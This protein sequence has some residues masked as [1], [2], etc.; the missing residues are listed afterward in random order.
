MS[1]YD[2]VDLSNWWRCSN[3]GEEFNDYDMLGNREEWLCL[4]C[5][6]L[7]QEKSRMRWNGKS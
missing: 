1:D 6:N 5:D 4:Y 3:C 2:E 7:K